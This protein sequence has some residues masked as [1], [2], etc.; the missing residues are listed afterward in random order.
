MEVNVPN[1]E[2]KQNNGMFIKFIYCVS[3]FIKKKMIVL[4]KVVLQN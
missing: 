1:S 4:Y 2:I 3:L